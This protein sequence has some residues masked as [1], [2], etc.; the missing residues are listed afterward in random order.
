MIRKK[1]KTSPPSVDSPPVEP[2]QEP[3]AAETTA[4]DEAHDTSD[5]TD[6]SDPVQEELATLREQ[7][8][9]LLADFDNFRKRTARERVDLIKHANEDLVTELLPV[10]DHFELALQQG[11]DSDDPF[12]KGVKMVF[13][14]L[15]STLHKV[16][17]LAAIQAPG[18]PFNPNFHDAI[19]YQPSDEVEEGVV[20]MQ[21][22]CGYKMGDRVIRPATVIVSS[23]ATN[24]TDTAET[25]EDQNGS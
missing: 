4:G 15:T 12:V 8:I 19:S 20:I 3:T 13:E 22:R 17:E 14:Q 24:D 7:N 6:P 11:N 10:L 1:N 25:A 9:R 16:A 2:N 5:E 23:G 18:T 21:A